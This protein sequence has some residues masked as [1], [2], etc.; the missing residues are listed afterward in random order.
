[1]P[2]EFSKQDGHLVWVKNPFTRT[3]TFFTQIHRKQFGFADRSPLPPVD[4]TVL[5]HRAEAELRAELEAAR[6]NCPFCPGNEH[7]TLDEVLRV[8]PAVVPDS[9]PT[10]SPWLIRA[11]YNLIPR[12]PESCTGGR[13]ESYVVVEDPRH[14]VDD[15]RHHEDLLYT[16]LLP[17]SQL[18]TILRTDIELARRARANPSVAA[19]LIRKNQGRDSGATQPHVHNQLI[20]S[21]FPFPPV[22]AEQEAL[23]AEPGL[24]RDILSWVEDEG[25]LI[26]RQEGCWLYFCPFGTHPRSYEI[27]CPELYGRITEL[28]AER[29]G[30]FAAALHQAL[31]ILGPIPA[32]YEIHDGPGLPLHAH[33]NARH[34]P[35]S[36]IGGTLNLPSTHTSN[37]PARGT[38]SGR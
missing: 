29:I 14:F 12:I 2:L 17:P 15:A 31:E 10:T 38:R 30:P 25:F 5:R 20:G 8:A 32:D 36:N 22:L 1:M 26:S 23:A 35:Y 24:W 11:F 13:N 6:T 9:A 33:V 16:A 37:L 27:V 28:P 21:A 18:E 34:F 3:I 19:T 4:D 7:L